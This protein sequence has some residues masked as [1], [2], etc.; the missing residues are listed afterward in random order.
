MASGFKVMSNSYLKSNGVDAHKVKDYYG[1]VPNS[2][3]DIYSGPTVT[4]RDKKG[5]LFADTGMSK[6][7]FFETYGVTMKEKYKKERRNEYILSWIKSS[8]Q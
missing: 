7:L 6:D 8:F 1:A 5:N 2:R 4:I 3:Y